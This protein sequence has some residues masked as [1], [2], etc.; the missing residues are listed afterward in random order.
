VRLAFHPSALPALGLA[1]D[2]V[3]RRN[4]V[5]LDRAGTQ[6]LELWRQPDLDE[7]HMRVGILRPMTS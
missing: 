3:R 5:Q 6:R 4:G 2:Q 7:G 1:M